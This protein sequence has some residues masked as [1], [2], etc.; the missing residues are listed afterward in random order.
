MNNKL[1]N[2]LH[3]LLQESRKV[4]KDAPRISVFKEL[5]PYKDKDDYYISFTS[6]EKIGVN[7][8]STFRTP[9]GIYAYPLKQS[10]EK[11]NVGENKKVGR[12]MPYAGS[13]QYVWL[14]KKKKGIKFVNSAEDYTE[15]DLEAD[16]E[17]LTEYVLKNKE[18]YYKSF[19]VDYPYYLKEHMVENYFNIWG[20][21]AN[22]KLPISKLWNITRNL[23][24]RGRDINDIEGNTRTSIITNWNT[25]FYK[26]LGY[27]GFADK[28]GVGY[29]HEH[30]PIQAVFFTKTAFDVVKFSQN[31]ERD[32]NS[33]EEMANKNWFYRNVDDQIETS[34]AVVEPMGTSR[35]K[36]KNGTWH[37]GTWGNGI[38]INGTWE[39]GEW[40]RGNWYGGIWRG[41]TWRGGNWYNGTWK[42]GNFN[43]GTWK[44]ERGMVA[45]G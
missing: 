11:Y 14:V 23:A 35:I 30:E 38:W 15:A 24:F 44:K 33:K 19:F 37:D 34:N 13:S 20:R 27:Y 26:V 18:R 39:D 4:Y 25:L 42:G 29:I 45:Y 3:L 31:K 9:L 1:T 41:G 7:P 28:T 2:L 10:W 17:R 5:E 8:Q 6:I 32:F 16:K 12:S 21:R 40:Q 22:K 43:K 36:W